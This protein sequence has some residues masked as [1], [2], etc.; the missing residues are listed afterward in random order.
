MLKK[1]VHDKINEVFLEYQNANHI[2]SG[3]I[4]PFDAEYLDRLEEELTHHIERVCAKQP[5]EINFDDFTPSWYIYTDDE[6]IPCS[7]TFDGDVEAN[8]FFTDVSYRIAF[9][10]CSGETVQ[11]IYFK[12]KEVEYVGWQQGMKFEYKDLDGNTVWVGVFEHWDH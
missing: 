5:K 8:Q 4:E 7:R 9:D 1:L 6:G 11:K 10:D 12:G 2:T 3:D